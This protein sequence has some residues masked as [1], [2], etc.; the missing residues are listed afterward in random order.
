M[1]PSMDMVQEPPYVAAAVY[2]H[3]DRNHSPRIVIGVEDE[4]IAEN[5]GSELLA[6]TAAGQGEFG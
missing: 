3:C 5:Q 1:S 4:M 2:S 6:V